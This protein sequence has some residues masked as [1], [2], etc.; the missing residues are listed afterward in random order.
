MQA[1]S[2]TTVE[3]AG[4]G[5]GEIAVLPSIT[6]VEIATDLLGGSSP[7]ARRADLPSSAQHSSDGSSGRTAGVPVDA[8]MPTMLVVLNPG[9]REMPSPDAISDKEVRQGPRLS[10]L[11]LSLVSGPATAAAAASPPQQQEPTTGPRSSS[12]PPTWPEGSLPHWPTSRRL[13]IRSSLRLDQILSGWL[14]HGFSDRADE[15]VTSRESSEPTQPPRG[16]EM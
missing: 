11:G 13:S 12:S 8:D 6:T 10:F 2:I 9:D 14:G 1:P 3:I 4:A 7:I 16:R 5:A 15:R